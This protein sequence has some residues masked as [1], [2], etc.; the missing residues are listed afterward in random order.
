M[1]IPI[2]RPAVARLMVRRRS[3]RSQ[4]IEGRDGRL[5]LGGDSNG[6]MAQITGR[7]KASRRQLD[8]IAATHED[9]ARLCGAHAIA[10]RHVICPSKESIETDKLPLELVYEGHGPSFVA[11]YLGT[12]P[13]TRPFYDR[14][15]LTGLDGAFFRL[16]T[17]WTEVG[18]G[19]YL[20][21]ALSHFDDERAKRLLHGLEAEVAP[22]L[23]P[24][25][26]GTKLGLGPESALGLYLP[27]ESAS[28]LFES[29]LINEGH[30]RWQR[31]S[32]PD[33]AGTR[34]LVLHDSSAAFLYR[35]LC[36]LYAETLFVH[37]PD[38]DASFLRR[39]RPDIVWCFQTE[40]FLPRVPCNDVDFG[41]MIA[42]AERRK[43]APVEGSRFLRETWP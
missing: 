7:V 31:S 32:R 1:A 16:D 21:A 27:N 5:F 28:L 13:S 2:L 3:G 40:R 23:L 25:D 10:Y 4:V 29:S 6:V 8:A 35:L 9:R 30:L 26:L 34:A 33:V 22:V 12:N 15:C 41:A 36:E 24:G 39:F 37:T 42:R 38:F 11:Q 19:A 43:K 14:S 20:D 18:A 17:H